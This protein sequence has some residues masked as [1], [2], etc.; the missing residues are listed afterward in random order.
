MSWPLQEDFKPGAP[1]IQVPMEWF[2]TVSKILNHLE[3]AGCR[4]H[5]TA[6][7]GSEAPWK[8]SVPTSGGGSSTTL[9]DADPV[10]DGTK[11]PGTAAAASRADHV[12][13][14]NVP[15]SGVPYYDSAAGS[16]GVAAE[17][18]RSDHSHPM[19]VDATAPAD[20]SMSAAAVGTI[21]KYARRDH[22]HKLPAPANPGSTTL[23]GFQSEGPSDAASA[24]SW[25]SGGATGLQLNIVARVRL[26]NASANPVLYAYVRVLKFTADGRLHS[27]SGEVAYAVS[28]T[29]LYS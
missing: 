21:G 24:T 3:G 19:N 27:V 23:I 18:S 11:T 16:Q 6:T 14:L 7:P 22:V 4:I 12:H 1:M 9:S 29:I 28:G 20:V 2:N 8:I 25:T 5:K 15:A 26:D 13:P 10:K 17:Y